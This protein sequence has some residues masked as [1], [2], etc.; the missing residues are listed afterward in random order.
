MGFIAFD[1]SSS[2]VTISRFHQY[3]SGAE[4]T[5]VIQLLMF[6]PCGELCGGLRSRGLC[7]GEGV[8][9]VCDVAD[10]GPVGNILT[11]AVAVAVAVAVTVTVAVLHLK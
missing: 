10:G 6:R 8:A 4:F 7:A 1:F 2:L 11:V 9:S 3:K 5:Q